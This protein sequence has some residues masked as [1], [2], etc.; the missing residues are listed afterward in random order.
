[1]QVK[2]NIYVEG[3]EVY[4]KIEGNKSEKVYVQEALENREYKLRRGEKGSDVLG[5]VFFERDV[6][7]EKPID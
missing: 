2:D 7:A 3:E 4:A 6:K 1:M 5:K